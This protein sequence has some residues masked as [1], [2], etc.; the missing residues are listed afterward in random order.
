MKYFKRYSGFKI[1]VTKSPIRGAN[2]Y[3]YFRPHLEKKLYL[4]SI[5]TVHH[6]LEDTDSNLKMNIFLDRYFEAK[7]I[8]CL[9]S[10]Q[11]KILKNH[12]ITNTLIIPHGYNNEVLNFKKNILK[13]KIIIGILSS[14]Y[15]RLVKGEDYVIKLFKNLSPKTFQFVLVG[16]KRNLLTKE[17][18]KLGFTCETYENLPYLFFNKIYQKINFLLITSNYEGGPASIPESIATGTPIITTKVGMANDFDKGLLILTKKLN[19]DLK[20]FNSLKKNINIIS[21]EVIPLSNKILTWQE[22]I[23]IYDNQFLILSNDNKISLY[24]KINMFTMSTR[25]KFKTLYLKKKL[26]TF[27]KYIFDIIKLLLNNKRI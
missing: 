27:P 12:G 21:E 8:V 17:L 1:I 18:E 20:L 25:Y 13:K 16:K 7:L 11:K 22:I 15:P 2:V 9:N 3:Y 19:K 14:Y 5:V 10:K 23:S 26:I 4:N 24:D 6:D